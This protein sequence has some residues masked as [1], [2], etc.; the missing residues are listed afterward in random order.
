MDRE[1]APIFRDVREAKDCARTRGARRVVL[2][3]GCFDPLHVGHLR[4]LEGAK[5]QGDFL[6]VALNDDQSTR[7]LK[8]P[9]RPVL[10]EADR[11]RLL[12]SLRMVDAVLLFGDRDVV[13]ILEAV[14][15]SCHAKGTDYTAETVPERETSR[16]LGIETAIVGD[17]KTH[18]SREIV[19][20]I[21]SRSRSGK[22]RG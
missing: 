16:R 2:A 18:A 14:V 13:R 21:Q 7:A 6:L 10:G 19:Q 22:E 9:K 5:A 8:G 3:N 1:R 12:A 4:Y 20:V 17:P 15:P 11:A